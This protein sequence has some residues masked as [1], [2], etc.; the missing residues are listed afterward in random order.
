MYSL[1][2]SS[3]PTPQAPGALRL[4][5]LTA[6]EVAEIYDLPCFTEEDRQIYFDLSPQEQAAVEA[7][8]THAAAI[9]LALQI[10]YFKASYRFFVYRREDV[11]ADLEY[12]RWRYFPQLD[13]SAMKLLSKPTR[14]AQQRVILDLFGYR[15]CDAAA[16]EAL[17]QKMRRTALLSTLPIFL[18]RDAFQYLTKQRLVAPGY[19]HLQE[20]VGRVVSHERLRITALL[21]TALTPAI[22]Q[23]LDDLLQADEGMHH[24]TVLKHEPRDF[25]YSQLRQ[26]GARRTTLQPL[27]VFAQSFLASTGVSNDSVRYYASLVQ[28][29][30]VY[31][32]ERMAPAT[33]RLY[34][35]CFAY[36]RFRQINDN[37]VDAFI[38]LVDQYE[39][40][41]KVSA[42]T[43]AHKALTEVSAH[44]GAAGKVLELFVDTTIPDTTPFVQVK[45]RAF[46][47][48]SLSEFPRSPPTCARSP[49]TRWLTSG[50]TSDRCGTSSSSTCGTCSSL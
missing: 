32:L 1:H 49:S 29:Y 13:A 2:A 25:S 11:R 33:R 42:E 4:T 16:K 12:L 19:T 27:Y 30:T 26:E 37:L 7:V 10:G 39:R 44:L 15:L 46:P 6:Q 17:E 8:Q 3:G 20:M 45:K 28:Y 40:Q 43:A 36:H 31:K 34:L 5:I 14:L 18:L 50:R 38:N 24:V 47:C 48:S 9:H 23:Q 35:L 21:S 41:A 22:R